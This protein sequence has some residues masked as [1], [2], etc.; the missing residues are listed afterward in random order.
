MGT[1]GVGNEDLFTTI[2]CDFSLRGVNERGKGDANKDR[3]NELL[4]GFGVLTL[5]SARP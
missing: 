3:N 1:V 2:V 5:E 4:H